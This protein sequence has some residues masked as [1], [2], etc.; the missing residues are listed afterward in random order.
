MD[1][2]LQTGHPE[3]LENDIRQV[4][5]LTLAPKLAKPP[6]PSK[7]SGRRDQAK[8]GEDYTERTTPHQPLADLK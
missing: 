2:W 3:A 5:M 6:H 1:P 4:L 8:A 7:V